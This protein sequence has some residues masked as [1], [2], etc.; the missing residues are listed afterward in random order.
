MTHWNAFVA[1]LEMH[2]K[3]R[4]FD[5]RLNQFALA[6]RHGHA[7]I[8]INPDDDQVTK[9]LA[10]LH[11]YQLALRSPQPPAGS[12]DKTAADRGDALFSGKAQCNNCHVEPLW[13]EP[14]GNMHPAR[15]VCGLLPG[16]PGA[17]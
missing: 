8:K 5:P 10:A 16:K 6:N 2:G 12:F 17:G 9:K 1:V 4:F 11:F 15:D 7:D 14:G 13:P 3:G